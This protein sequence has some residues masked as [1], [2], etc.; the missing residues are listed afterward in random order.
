M[1]IIGKQLV[2]ALASAVSP[3]RKPG[4]DTVRQMPGFCVMKPAMDA[5]Y[6]AFCSCRNEITRRP[7]RLQPAREVGD[8]DAGQAEDRI[9]AVQLEGV[10][11]E[12][13]AVGLLCLAL[14]LAARL[15]R[16]VGGRCGGLGGYLVHV[17][18]PIG[19][20]HVSGAARALAAGRCEG[21]ADAVFVQAAPQFARSRLQRREP[22]ESSKVEPR[23]LGFF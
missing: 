13:K 7:A 23:L 22:G 2:V 5:A 3:L 21:A 9:D 17:S 4:A 15:R 12:L 14:D 19:G 1:R 16:G 8:R 6:P 11:D 10:D 20:G 18:S